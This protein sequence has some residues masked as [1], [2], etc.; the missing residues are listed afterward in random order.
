MIWTVNDW[1]EFANLLVAI[2]SIV[3]TSFIAIWVVIKIQKRLEDDKALR[4]YLVNNLIYIRKV[5]RDLFVQ[6]NAGKAKAKD[7]KRLLSGQNQLMT[8]VLKM[9]KNKYNLEDK[10]FNSWSTELSLLVET[11]EKYN[12]AYAKNKVFK[13][14]TNELDDI[15]VSSNTFEQIITD[16]ILQLYG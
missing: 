13:L 12:D 5:Y 11:S 14:S 10:D 6:I 16:L 1:L 4:D 8:D 9:G 3:V 15:A 2:F 7:T